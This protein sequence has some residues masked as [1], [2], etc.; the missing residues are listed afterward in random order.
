M[1]RGAAAAKAGRDGAMG[2]RRR[3]AR[4]RGHMS[5]EDMDFIDEVWAKYDS[6]D[7]GS[8]GQ[9]EVMDLMTEINEDIPPSK[10]E[11][12]MLMKVADSDNSGTIDKDELKKLIATWFVMA[13]DRNRRVN[14]TN[15]KREV[16]QALNG[17]MQEDNTKATIIKFPGEE[18]VNYWKQTQATMDQNYNKPIAEVS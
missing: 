14:L 2:N 7:D 10:K 17:C 4:R 11:V 15:I 5:D 6:N 3:N 18:A 16:K 13:E 1:F 8:I 9:K 12:K